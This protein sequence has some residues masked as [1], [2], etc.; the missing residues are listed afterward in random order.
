MGRQRKTNVPQTSEQFL[1]QAF[2]PIILDH[3]HRSIGVR[4]LAHPVHDPIRKSALVLGAIRPRIRPLAVLFAV[5]PVALVPVTARGERE[6][7]EQKR[8]EST[9]NEDSARES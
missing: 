8:E 3:V 5:T 2:P 9:V 6:T 1:G 4:L 7:K